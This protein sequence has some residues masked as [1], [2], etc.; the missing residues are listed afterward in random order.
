MNRY[1]F[2][3]SLTLKAIKMQENLFA[4]SWKYLL[5]M[6]GENSVAAIAGISFDPFH[7]DLFSS[8]LLSKRQEVLGAFFHSNP[9]VM[10]SSWMIWISE[11]SNLTTSRNVLRK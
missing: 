3:A 10:R 6:S 11:Q 9:M 7:L 2:Y 1:Y 8:S 4:Y 5:T